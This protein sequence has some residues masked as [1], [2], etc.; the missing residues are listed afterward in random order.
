MPRAVY[1]K[2]TRVQLKDIVES[3]NLQQEEDTTAREL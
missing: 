3:C 1:D 2:T